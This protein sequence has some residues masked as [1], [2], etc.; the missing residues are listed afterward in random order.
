MGSPGIDLDVAPNPRTK[1]EN[2]ERAFIA[3]SRRKDRSLDARVESANRASSLH[4]QR[5]GK[6]LLIS[7]DIVEREAMY[8]EV[9]DRYQ[10][11]INR[12]LHAQSIQLHAEF[13]R[14]LMAAWHGARPGGGLHQRR[15]A[16]AHL[17]PR[18]SINGIR[19]MSLDLSGLRSSIAED[20]R[21]QPGPMTSPLSANPSSYVLSPT[22]DGTVQSPSY[23]NVV[24]A[25]AG[26]V[27]SYLA[28]AGGPTWSPAPQQQ[29]LGPQQPFRSPWTAGYISPQ[30]PQ[31]AISLDE[32]A[33]MPVRQFRDRMASAPV[34]PVHA[35]AA[36]P[37]MGTP[38]VG[39]TTTAAT[40]TPS[41]PAMSRPVNVIQHNRVRSEPGQTVLTN[42]LPATTT[43][44]QMSSPRGS[45][46]DMGSSAEP[47]IPTP[48]LCP[49]PSTPHSP[50][51]T[52]QNPSGVWGLDLGKD[53]GGM[54]V[55]YQADHLDPEYDEFSRF[56]FGLGSGSQLPE[57]DMGFDE[58]FTL[59]EY[60]VSA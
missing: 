51:S 26:Q 27:P 18:A 42:G 52:G 43:L 41:T 23:P 58:F 60:P 55:T 46:Q 9:D 8:E 31:P 6:A 33:A 17:N 37:L 36:S 59:E 28:Q 21:V 29:P 19:K 57:T 30:P 5:T 47:I 15:A 38:A 14:N 39:G 24:S 54:E 44:S 53:E 45:G 48:D 22:L 50:H 10:E 34:I 56:A 13:N 12:M 35:I 40:V 2:Q 1:E 7:R 16:S 3:A 11:K 32:M 4:K 49:T 20:C 25:S